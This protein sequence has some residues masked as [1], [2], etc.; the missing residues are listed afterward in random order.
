MKMDKREAI[1]FT[2][3]RLIHE[4]GYNKV[5]L[6]SILDELSIPKGSF[7][8]YFKSKED[9]GLSIIEIYIGDTK[10]CV[11]EVE[12]NLEGLKTFY[13]IFFDR[14]KALSLKRGCPVGNLILEL[15]DQNEAFR[16]KLYEWY[17]LLNS[18]TEKILIEASVT[19]AENKAK[20]LTAAFEG[21][22]MLSKLDKNTVHF[23]IFNSVTFEAIINQ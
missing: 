13:G 4:Q 7:Y 8:H 23:D 5:G 10:T 12:Q 14:L 1:I 21:S 17:D 19:N 16:E 18:W 22:M 20:A 9:L 3:A 15:S 2:A 6:K 11:E